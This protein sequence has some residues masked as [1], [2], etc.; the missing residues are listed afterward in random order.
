MAVLRVEQFWKEVSNNIKLEWEIQSMLS[1]PPVING[2]VEILFNSVNTRVLRA[3]VFLI[4]ELRLRDN[5][6]IETLMR[7]DSNVECVLSLFK[8]GLVVAIV[9]ICLLRP[10]TA[11]LLEMNVVD[12]LLTIIR[13]NDDDSIKMCMKPKTAS[14]LLLGQI[15]KSEDK[16]T[17]SEITKRVFSEKVIENIV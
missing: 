15:L 4:S 14:V 1:K 8:K 11:T 16:S 5:G 17:V 10:L 13:R 6:V 9:L 7:V 2:F 12:L 3:T